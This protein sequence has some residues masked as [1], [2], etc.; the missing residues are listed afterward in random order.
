MDAEI[1]DIK[2]RLATVEQ[3]I[4]SQC[5]KCD[6]VCKDFSS[7]I[8]E[9]RAIVESMREL[10]VAVTKLTEQIKH[11]SDEVIDM[12]AQLAE[13]AKQPAAKWNLLT[14]AIITALTSGLITII[15]N[16]ML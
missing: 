13:V 10:N 6:Y 4:S 15:L 8:Q 7:K 9:T 2:T 3:K 5:D 12:K 14:G 11:N 16:T 1:I